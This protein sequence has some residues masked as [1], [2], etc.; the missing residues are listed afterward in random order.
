MSRPR[1]AALVWRHWVL[2]PLY[3]GF[4]ALPLTLVGRSGRLTGSPTPSKRLLM[5][6]VSLVSFVLAV[7]T[8]VTVWSGE[9]YPLRPDVIG[10]LDHMFSAFP[11]GENA[12]GGP[13]VAGAW[14][15]HATS[16]F[17]IQVLALSVIRGLT[18][19]V[20]SP[21]DTPGRGATRSGVS[22]DVTR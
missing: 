4:A 13:T 5:F 6:P 17:G 1:L 21:S 14:F 7:V 2:E 22:G 10:H 19:L 16:G 15:V 3:F 9:L 12:W 11:G 18:A 20:T 8:V